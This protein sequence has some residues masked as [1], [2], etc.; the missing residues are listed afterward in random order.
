MFTTL[1]ILPVPLHTEHDLKVTP[2]AVTNLFT[3]IF[4]STP[5]AISLIDNLSFILR[6]D[7]LFLDELLLPP[8]KLSKGLPPPP[9]KISPN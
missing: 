1:L 5:S 8:K 2:E 3:F 4:F 6:F 9:P 7:P